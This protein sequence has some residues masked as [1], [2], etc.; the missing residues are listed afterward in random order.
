MPLR[1]HTDVNL[2]THE[3]QQAL[4]QRL[5]EQ[6]PHMIIVDTVDAALEAKDASDCQVMCIVEDGQPT[7]YDLSLEHGFLYKSIAEVQYDLLH[8]KIIRDGALQQ[9]IN[10]LQNELYSR[11]PNIANLQ[12]DFDTYYKP[13]ILVV[14]DKPQQFERICQIVDTDDLSH[15]NIQHATSIDQAN[16]YAAN[17]SPTMIFLDILLSGEY[18]QTFF[19]AYSE[20]YRVVYLT[21]DFVHSEAAKEIKAGALDYLRKPL[22]LDAGR[23][24]I[25]HYFALLKQISFLR[26][27]LNK[28]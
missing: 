6:E 28:N 16:K 2:V 10:E 17:L 19:K 15:I 5:E 25:R 18:G 8:Q 20:K 7:E 1:D 21:N 14:D 12:S 22:P 26:F 11:R 4:V 3:D 23:F 13:T 9:Y 24:Y 27:S